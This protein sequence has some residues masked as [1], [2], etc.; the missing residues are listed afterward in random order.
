MQRMCSSAEGAAAA[1]E[2][3]ER[4]TGASSHC[5]RPA[6]A[7][8][9]VGGLPRKLR[10]FPPLDFLCFVKIQVS[11]PCCCPRP[12]AD[13]KHWQWGLGS[14]ACNGE[15]LKTQ[16]LGSGTV[17]IVC[18]P[19]GVGLWQDGAQAPKAQTVCWALLPQL[20]RVRGCTAN[21]AGLVAVG[22]RVDPASG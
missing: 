20:C 14:A 8:S 12:R 21:R 7:C 18:D 17:T 3:G 5:A 22:P 2:G 9:G 16:E 4:G 13:P 10:D 11:G 15:P 6:A 19:A 1:K